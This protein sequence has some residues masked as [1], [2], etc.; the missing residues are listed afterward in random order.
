LL[1][2]VM[3]VSVADG[4][5]LAAGNYDAVIACPSAASIHPVQL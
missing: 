1:L 4:V 2:L 3:M 5:P